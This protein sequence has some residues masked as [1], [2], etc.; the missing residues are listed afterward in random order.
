MR[1][2]LGDMEKRTGKRLETF[3]DPYPLLS[4]S[5]AESRI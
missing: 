1:L 4:L 3:L 2:E 5:F